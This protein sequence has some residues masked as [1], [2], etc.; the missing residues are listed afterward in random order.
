MSRPTP[1]PW[2]AHE[3]VLQPFAIN[4]R[5]ERE[6]RDFTMLDL[7]AAAGMNMSEISRLEACERDPYLTT[8]VR[9]ARGL[10][11]RPTGLLRGIR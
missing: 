10:G 1:R 9:V 4:L 5:H 3:A 6:R 8:V 11:V 7:A 2:H